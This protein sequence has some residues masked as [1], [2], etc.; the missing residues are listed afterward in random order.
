MHNIYEIE[1]EKFIM[2]NNATKCVSQN[3][4]LKIFPFLPVQE[5]FM[6]HTVGDAQKV[7]FCLYVNENITR[8]TW[9]LHTI[10]TCLGYWCW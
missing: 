1:S 10:A 2:L 7:T 6:S 9:Q 5:Q 3:V 8:G 4:H